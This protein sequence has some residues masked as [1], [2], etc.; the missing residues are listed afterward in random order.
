MVNKAVT[1]KS[2]L[3]RAFAIAFLGLLRFLNGSSEG[4]RKHHDLGLQVVGH[5]QLAG[6]QYSHRRNSKPSVE[7]IEGSVLD[8]ANSSLFSGIVITGLT[9]TKQRKAK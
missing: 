9:C 7:E 3:L 2:L 8:Q 1:H 5:A 6:A 4:R